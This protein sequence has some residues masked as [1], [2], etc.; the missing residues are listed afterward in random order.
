MYIISSKKILQIYMLPKDIKRVTGYKSVTRF[1][2]A[3]KAFCKERP[4][5]FG[6]QKPYLEMEGLDTIYN[7]Y[8]YLHWFENRDLFDSGTR[9]I[10]FED[11]LPR[12]QALLQM[13]SVEDASID[14]LSELKKKVLEVSADIER[15]K[16]AKVKVV[17]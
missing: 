12:I 5:H 15:L 14:E 10:T 1:L 9:S 16:N 11:D 13:A 17:I 7:I 8:C 6:G 4:Q 2:N 3:F